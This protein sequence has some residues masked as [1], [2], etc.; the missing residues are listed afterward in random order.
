MARGT[1]VSLAVDAA[2]LAHALNIPRLWRWTVGAYALTAI[3][4]IACHHVEQSNIIMSNEIIR[5]ILVVPLLNNK[6]DMTNIPSLVV[7][8]IKNAAQKRI[9]NA[10]IKKV[11]LLLDSHQ[12]DAII[13]KNQWNI[14]KSKGN[15]KMRDFF[16]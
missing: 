2:V 10:P 9:K 3:A 6:G 4:G 1:W 16:F 14:Y 12:F 5:I 8:P 7:A 15:F 13:T 11:F